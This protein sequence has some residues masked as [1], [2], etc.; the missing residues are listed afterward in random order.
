MNHL[1]LT[2]FQVNRVEHKLISDKP[3]RDELAMS[4]FQGDRDWCLTQLKSFKFVKNII[5]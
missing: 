1:Y 5:Y 2:V 3:H 4:C